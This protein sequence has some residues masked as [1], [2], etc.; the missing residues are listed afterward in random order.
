MVPLAQLLHNQSP[1][2]VL[3]TLLNV[4]SLRSV[5]YQ[6]CSHTSNN[7]NAASGWEVWVG[8]HGESLP[9]TTA[10]ATQLC[11]VIG[12]SKVRMKPEPRASSQGQA[13]SLVPQ[14]SVSEGA[15]SS[16]Y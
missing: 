7:P 1:F 4:H 15:K 8:C 16:R 14:C 13:A 12:T 9:S 5:R 10:W 6:P 3:F 11:F 2:Q